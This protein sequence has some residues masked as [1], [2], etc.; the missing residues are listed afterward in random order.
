MMC[1]IYVDD[2]IFAG[3]NQDM[4]F[5]EVNLLGIK[6]LHE[7]QPLEFRDEGEVSPFIG[8]KIKQK[9]LNKYYLSQPGLID[10][11]LTAAGMQ[12]Y[13]PNNT[14]STLDP[15]GLDKDGQ[16]LDENWEYVLIIGMLMYL[17][18][19]TRPDKLM[20]SMHVP[21]THIIPRRYMTL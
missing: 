10:K 17:T 9:G 18:N 7:E 13:N 16:P 20:L 5:K 1:V 4:I 12:D 19:N 3:P 14:S 6:Q 2:T 11:I 8:I 21:G 15:L